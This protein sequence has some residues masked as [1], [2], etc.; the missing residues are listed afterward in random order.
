[1]VLL[2]GIGLEVATSRPQPH[3]TSSP[4]LLEMRLMYSCYHEA[5][6]I[7]SLEAHPVIELTLLDT[8]P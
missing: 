7:M 5:C 6:V 1:M 8:H 2:T 4:N 3:C